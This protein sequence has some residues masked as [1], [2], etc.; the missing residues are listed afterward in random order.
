MVDMLIA[1]EQAVSITHRAA[2]SLEDETATRQRAVS[3]A[4][5][6]VGR[7]GRFVAQAAVQIHGGIGTTDELD[8]SHHFRRIELLD[9]QLGTID[10]HVR[11]Y[12]SLLDRPEPA[13]A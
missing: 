13:I 8:V 12:A 9:L 1:R 4:K 11:R 2:L 7:L 5:A 6:H 10:D 3:A